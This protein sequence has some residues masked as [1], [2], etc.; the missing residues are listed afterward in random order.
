MRKIKKIQLFS[1]FSNKT[2]IHVMN[3][4]IICNHVF[5]NIIHN[6]IKYCFKVL[7]NTSQYYF[8]FTWGGK[9]A[10]YGLAITFTLKQIIK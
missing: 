7:K 4:K 8:N 10:R 9:I 2:L 5:L 3:I 6:K 1:I